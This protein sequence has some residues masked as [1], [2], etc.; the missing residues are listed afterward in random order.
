MVIVI[1]SALGLR[2]R[3]DRGRDQAGYDAS[4]TPT[5]LTTPSAPQP[6]EELRSNDLSHV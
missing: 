2:T 4:M 1:A 5:S 6:H 3:M